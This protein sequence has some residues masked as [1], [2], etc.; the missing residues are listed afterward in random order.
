[1][2]A[3]VLE[4]RKPLIIQTV[5][6]LT[7]KVVI[8]EVVVETSIKSLTTIVKEAIVK[9]LITYAEATMNSQVRRKPLI[10][11]AVAMTV[12]SLTTASL[13]VLA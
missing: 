9:S 7:T 10:T 6:E 5:I 2:I 11:E 1:M 4:Y 8:A 13:L 3:E 12:N